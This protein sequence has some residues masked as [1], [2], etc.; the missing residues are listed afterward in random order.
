MLYVDS[1]YLR[2][3]GA[4]EESGHAFGV[5]LMNKILD[6]PAG[7]VDAPIKDLNFGKDILDLVSLSGA[8][9]IEPSMVGDR[10]HARVASRITFANGT[11]AP[12]PTATWLVDPRQ[13]DPPV[14]ERDLRST[15]MWQIAGIDRPSLELDL[16]DRSSG[17]PTTQRM[18]LYP[19]RRQIRLRIYCSPADDLPGGPY[20]PPLPAGSKAEHFPG[21]YALFPHVPHA[22]LTLL[23]ERTTET[24][25]CTTARVA[26]RRS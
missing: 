3:D 8:S 1:A 26:V 13:P 6:V 21:F 20:K 4:D 16:V 7:L 12:T 17:F 19:K 2:S 9:P 24:N 14:E 18:T 23:R 5:P 15:T 25:Q 22:E 11:P 10:L